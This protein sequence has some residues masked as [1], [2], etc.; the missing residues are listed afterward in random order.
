MVVER[1]IN[2]GFHSNF[3]TFKRSKHSKTHTRLAI[4]NGFPFNPTTTRKI[5]V[6]NVARFPIL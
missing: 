3:D 1:T 4:T 2:V 5:V 6:I